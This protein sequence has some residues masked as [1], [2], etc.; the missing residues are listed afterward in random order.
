MP[1]LPLNSAITQTF[2]AEERSGNLPLFSAVYRPRIQ[3]AL[4]IQVGGGV[5]LICLC[6]VPADNAEIASSCT[7]V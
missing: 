7:W 4:L 1:L 6:F 3:E 2:D 5:Q